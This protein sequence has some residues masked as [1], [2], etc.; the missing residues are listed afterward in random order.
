MSLWRKITWWV[1]VL[2]SL[3]VWAWASGARAADAVLTW[4][5]N[6]EADLAGYRVYFGTGVTTC[7]NLVTELSPLLVAGAP[8][9]LGK[10]ATYTHVALPNLDTTMCWEL[11]AIDTAVPPNESLRSVRVSKVLNLLPPI[12]PGGLGVAIK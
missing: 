5:P 6:T 12:P 10:V 9:Q 3:G 8:V 2:C 7:A 1:V 4:T 11:T